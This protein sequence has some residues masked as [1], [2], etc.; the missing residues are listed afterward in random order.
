MSTFYSEYFYEPGCITT[1]ILKLRRTL[2]VSV[3][4][5]TRCSA[6]IVCYCL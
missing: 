3:L 4:Y 2:Q 1:M 5:W 6:Y